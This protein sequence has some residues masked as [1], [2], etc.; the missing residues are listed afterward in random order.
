VEANPGVVPPV[1]ERSWAAEFANYQET[2]EF[3]LRTVPMTLDE[4][5]QIYWVE[6]AHRALARFTGLVF[7]VPL[8]IWTIRG[9]LRGVRLYRLLALF[10]L[11]LMQGAVGWWM[12]KSGL[13]RDARV[14]PYRL[15]LHLNL[16]LVLCGGLVWCAASEWD[17]RSCVKQ[18]KSASLERLAYLLVLVLLGAT[19]TWGALMAGLH[20]GHIAPTFPRMNG[21][22]IPPGLHIDGSAVFEDPL[23]VHFVHRALA[24]LSFVA[25]IFAAGITLRRRHRLPRDTRWPTL[26]PSEG[27]ACA[28]LALLAVQVSLG[29]ATV[30][31]HVALSIALLHQAT[32]A[33]V[34]MCAVLSMREQG[35]PT[36]Q[37]HDVLGRNSN[38]WCPTIARTLWS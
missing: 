38:L 8:V 10:V 6:W 14:S 21:A 2:P 34:L 24:A 28:L 1:D 29:I 7:L 13:I 15:A 3:L 11:G 35:K 20:A 32:G 19:E 12:V 17:R 18:Y 4:F 16:A 27:I 36:Q 33:L 37:N 31:S 22:W 26:C 30:L 25:G 23:T 9:R 5:Q